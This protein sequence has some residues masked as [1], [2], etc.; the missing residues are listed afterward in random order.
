MYDSVA[1]TQLSVTQLWERPAQLWEWLA[2]LDLK[3]GNSSS[4]SQAGQLGAQA[5]LK[6]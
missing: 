3:P 5:T 1:M 2:Q 4:Q 6:Q